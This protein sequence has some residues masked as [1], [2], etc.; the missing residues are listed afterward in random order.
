MVDGR[1]A[2]GFPGQGVDWAGVVEVLHEESTDPL[3]ALLAERTGVRDWSTVDAADTA[4]AQA[5]IFTAG[6]VGAR[7]VGLEGVGVLAGHSFGEL[8]ALVTGGVLSE[9]D[10]L[11]LALVRGRLGAE[12]QQAHGGSM[13]AVVGIP[14]RRVERLRRQALAE[15]GGTCELAVR[16][17]AHQ[18]VLS[19]DGP[20]LGWIEARARA[21]DGRAHVLPIGAPYHTPFM[22]GAAERYV[23]A[24]EAVPRSAPVLPVLISTNPSAVVRTTTDVGAVPE[25]LGDSL[26][27]PVDW[28][29][30]LAMARELGADRGLDVGPGNVLARIGRRAGL[31]FDARWLAPEPAR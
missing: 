11:E 29:E 1:L 7:L 9:A 18:V 8:A 14:E 15:V 17:H 21:L 30:T 16:N 20:P 26:V 27:L 5:A 31:G 23:D 10:G 12:V 28:P 6:V 25:L 19:G 13:L 2:L 4:R 24:V 22:A 3:V